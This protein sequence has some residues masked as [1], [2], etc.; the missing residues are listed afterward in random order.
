MWSTEEGDG[1]PLWYSCFENPMNSMKRQKDMTLEDCW[2]AQCK[3][4]VKGESPWE[5]GEGPEV[6]GFVLRTEKHLLPLVM[7]GAKI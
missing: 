2:E 3:I 7:L 6:P 5:N 1:K 4:A